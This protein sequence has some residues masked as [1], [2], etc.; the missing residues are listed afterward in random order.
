MK[1]RPLIIVE[2]DDISTHVSWVDEEEAN[3]IDALKCI[4]VG[5]KLKSDKKYLKITP[6]RASNRDCS[7][8]Q[9]IPR[10]CI[11]KIRKLE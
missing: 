2:W 8:V 9:T 11:H 1:K 6:M 7:D 10:G 4:S 5:W 3:K